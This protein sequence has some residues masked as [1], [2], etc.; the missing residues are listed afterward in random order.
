[1]TDLEPEVIEKLKVRAT[2]QGRK[3]EAEIKAIVL[4]AVE[5]APAPKKR[6][7][8]ESRQIFEEAGQ[9]YA[10]RKFSDSAELLREDRQR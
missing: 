1:M 8:A 6:T 5:P 7:L 9:R 3:L 2:S 4:A 10:G